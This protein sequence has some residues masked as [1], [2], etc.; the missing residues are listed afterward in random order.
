MRRCEG[1]AELHDMA[2]CARERMESAARALQLWVGS[3]G[4][5]VGV[6]GQ[7]MTHPFY[8]CIIRA[9]KFIFYSVAQICSD[10]AVWLYAARGRKRLSDVTRCDLPESSLV[11]RTPFSDMS[12]CKVVFN[13]YPLIF[14]TFWTIPISLRVPSSSN[15]YYFLI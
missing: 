15:F 12:C 6:G 11:W 10:F 3:R 7:F 1:R 4:V 14:S 9:M 2:S 13:A 8:L 5:G